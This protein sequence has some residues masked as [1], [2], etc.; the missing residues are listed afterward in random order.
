MRSHDKVT[1]PRH[2]TV[3]PEKLASEEVGDGEGGDSI[4]SGGVEIAK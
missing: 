2:Y 4:D 1:W 3:S